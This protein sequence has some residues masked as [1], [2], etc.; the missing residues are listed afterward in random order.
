MAYARRGR[1]WRGADGLPLEKGIVEDCKL[2]YRVCGVRVI[3]FVQTRKTMQT[4]G[5]PDLKLYHE[6]SGLTWWH[7]VKRPKGKQ[8]RAQKEFQE[9]AEA[10]GEE[11]LIGGYDA[12]IDKLRELKL[13]TAG[14]AALRSGAQKKAGGQPED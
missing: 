6:K 4:P 11:Y 10:C 13:L 5:I 12:A 3:S 14:E 7:E 9:L 1:Q 2:L 8:S